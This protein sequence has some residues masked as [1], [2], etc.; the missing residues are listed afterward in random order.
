MSARTLGHC[1]G[2]KPLDR[3]QI[4]NRRE[5]AEM[6]AF[7][8]PRGKPQDLPFLFFQR[9]LPDGMLE[10]RSTS[11][12][13]TRVDPLEVCDIIPGVPVC[14][15]AMPRS[16]FLARLK[17]PLAERG[18]PAPNDSYHSAS[19]RYVMKDRWGRIDQVFV[20]FDDDTLNRDAESF[21]TPVTARDR[22]HLNATATRSTMPVM[23]PGTSAASADKGLAHEKEL[24]SEAAQALVA[25]ALAGHAAGVERITSIG[26]VPIKRTQVVQVRR[27]AAA[28]RR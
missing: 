13:V 22:E 17:L 19:V 8:Q 21:A 16:V 7:S 6:R 18:A 2:L 11:G 25:C 12:Y 15:R 10:V 24:H 3:L 28:M 23:G 27:Q 4:A 9:V 20:T 26:A 14:V 5:V 1:L